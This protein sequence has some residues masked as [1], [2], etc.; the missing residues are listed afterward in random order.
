MKFLHSSSQRSRGGFAKT[1]A[2]TLLEKPTLSSSTVLKF[3]RVF[4]GLYRALIYP[5]MLPGPTGALWIV[6]H[7]FVNYIHTLILGIRVTSFPRPEIYPSIYIH[8]SHISSCVYIK[9]HTDMDNS[10]SFTCATHIPHPHSSLICSWTLPIRPNSFVILP[11]ALGFLLCPP[12]SL[13]ILLLVRRTPKFGP[14]LCLVNS[15]K[16]MFQ[17]FIRNIPASKW[18]EIKCAPHRHTPHNT[19]IL[20]L[21]VDRCAYAAAK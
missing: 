18:R 8:S 14:N 6:I 10:H 21:P 5:V 9:N 2:K 7:N 1:Q 19:I 13:A 15:R 11:K 12:F 16:S 3:P 17:H 4:R 20:I